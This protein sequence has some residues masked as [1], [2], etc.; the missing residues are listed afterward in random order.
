[1]N[2]SQAISTPPTAPRK[3]QPSSGEAAYEPNSRATTSGS[4]ML[5]SGPIGS[6]PTATSTPSG[7]GSARRSRGPRACSPTSGSP[8][9]LP[10]RSSRPS[11][12]S[13]SAIAVSSMRSATSPTD[14]T[15][16]VAS[17]S[18]WPEEFGL[19]GMR[20]LL[21]RLGN[22]QAR[23]PAIHVVG[24]N[25]KSTATRTIAELLRSEG[26]RAGAYTSPHVA[27]WHERLDCDEAA[28]E[29]AVARVR[30]PAEELGST[31][32]EVLT[33]AALLGFAGQGVDV[34][35]VEA[36]LGGR[37]DATN[38]VD[39]E[40]VLLTNVALEHTEVL[41]ETREEIAQEKL[42]VAHA[43]RVVV[44]SDNTFEHLLPPDAELV[45]G[46]AKEAGEAFLGRQID[47][48]VQVSL[49]GRL[50]R[51][52]DEIRDGAHTPEAMDW[53][54]ARIPAR[55]YV[56]CVSILGDKR[57]DELLERLRR[58]GSTFV[59]TRSSNPRALPAKELAARAEPHFS[60]V[61][62]VADPAK[63]LARA[64]TFGRP[65]LVTGSLYLLADLHVREEDAG[66]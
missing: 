47:H 22:P 62:S 14:A 45:Q 29:R 51:R 4:S 44:V 58:A 2:A 49:A 35:V 52:N 64:R 43:A 7:S 36:G 56:L 28:F 6:R 23:Y 54:L 26:L 9:G 32:F 33:A 39:A 27:G 30:K 10:P 24:T 66:R 61:I 15:A 37:L 60:E 18:P 19:D 53:L 5:S 21:A 11:G 63:A 40:V 12:R 48:D 16:W 31:Q 55:D 25:G 13:S 34:A 3:Q 41:G 20:A 65:V 17:L 59:A 8:R 1:M 38:V 46:G 50:E 42:A 57:V